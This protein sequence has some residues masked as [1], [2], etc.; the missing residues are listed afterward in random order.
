MELLRSY[1]N[2]IWWAETTSYVLFRSEK[3]SSTIAAEVKRVLDI[4]K[5]VAIISSPYIKTMTII[6]TNN[7][8]DIF[9]LVD[10]AKWG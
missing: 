4:S 10:F 8:E 5:D 2:T 1:D 3:S 9:K 7:D 6:G